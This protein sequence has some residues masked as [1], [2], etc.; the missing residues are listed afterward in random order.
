[1]TE[2]TI[3]EQSSVNIA[4]INAASIMFSK[5]EESTETP[6]PSE[7][8][9]QPADEQDE[10]KQKEAEKAPIMPQPPTPK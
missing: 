1:M 4:T 7:G 10:E 2:Q 9:Y 8:T 6:E 3:H 5:D